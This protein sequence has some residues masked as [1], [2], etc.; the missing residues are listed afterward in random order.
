[1]GLVFLLHVGLVVLKVRARAGL[2][3]AVLFEPVIE[4]IVQKLATVVAVPSEQ[5][6]G[7]AFPDRFENFEAG[8]LA[9]PS[10]DLDEHIEQTAPG[11]T[12][13]RSPVSGPH[14]FCE[15]LYACFNHYHGWRH[16]VSFYEA[17]GLS[18]K[19]LE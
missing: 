10:S 9:L 16:A 13:R 18:R 2:V 4:V 8:V 1:M 19:F 5:I 3:N 11:L 17:T 6:E 12:A 15:F 14:L 7:L